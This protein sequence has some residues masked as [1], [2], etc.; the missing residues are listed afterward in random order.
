MK[1][2]I[3]LIK[4]YTV[5]IVN[6]PHRKL[7]RRLKDKSDKNHLYPQYINTQK[8]LNYDVNTVNML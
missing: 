2:K 8:D 7:I 3:S 5:T 1:G 6:Q 4:A